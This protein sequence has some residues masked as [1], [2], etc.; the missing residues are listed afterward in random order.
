MTQV[1]VHLLLPPLLGWLAGQ[2][3]ALRHEVG[4]GHVG[5]AEA[6]D[7]AR[8]HLMQPVALHTPDG[9]LYDTK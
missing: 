2:V 3:V 4:D 5:E 1:L 7:A 8:V 6:G 9:N